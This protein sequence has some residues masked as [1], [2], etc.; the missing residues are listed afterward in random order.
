M[1]K[2]ISVIKEKSAS[3]EAL[4]DILTQRHKNIR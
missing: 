1:Y 3:G 4:A 2:S